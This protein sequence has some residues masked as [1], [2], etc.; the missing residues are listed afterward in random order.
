MDTVSEVASLLKACG[1][2]LRLQL[3][4]AIE[5]GEEACVSELWNCLEQSQ[6]VVSQ[7]LAVLK[8]RGIVASQV[9]GNRRVYTIVNPFVRDLIDSL[10]RT[11]EESRGA[12]RK[13]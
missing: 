5:K 10:H 11:V 12:R 7:H 1:H 4:C 2:P 3:L 8:R 13:A 6:P 9:Q